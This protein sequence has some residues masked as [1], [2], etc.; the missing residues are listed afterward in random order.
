MIEEAK[1]L[2]IKVIELRDKNA[3]LAIYDFLR[4]HG[5]TANKPTEIDFSKEIPKILER[6]NEELENKKILQKAKE[7]LR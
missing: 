6:Y 1:K 3:L 5:V 4:T 7:I 2:G